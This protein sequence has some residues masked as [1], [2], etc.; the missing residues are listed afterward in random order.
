MNIKALT[1][2]YFGTLVDV[3]KGGTLGMAEVLR[4]LT[5]ETER[6]VFEVYLDWDVRNVRLYRGAAYQRY[7]DVSQQALMASLNTLFPGALEGHSVE[8]L[9]DIL[10]A[11]L[12]EASPPHADAVDF[13]EW[14]QPIYPLMPITNISPTWTATSGSVASL[15][16][17]SSTSPR[18]K[19]PGPINRRRL[20]SASRWTVSDCLRPTCCTVRSRAGPTLTARNRWACRSHG[21]TVAR[22]S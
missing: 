21:S 17:I 15:C 2:D 1:F 9:T 4:R 7:R 8:K 13:L 10:L 5:V 12:V 19:W 11:H 14:A 22:T 18:R 16:V 6:P 20:F 3:D